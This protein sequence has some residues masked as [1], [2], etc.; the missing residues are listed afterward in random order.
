[1][2]FS[3]D[4]SSVVLSQTS[5]KCCHL[6]ISI[7]ISPGVAIK[8]LHELHIIRRKVTAKGIAKY[9]IQFLQV[10]HRRNF[11]SQNIVHRRTSFYIVH[12]STSQKLYI[13]E[14]TGYNTRQVSK[15]QTGSALVVVGATK[16]R[17]DILNKLM[18]I[19]DTHT[20]RAHR[21]YI[22]TY[23]HNKL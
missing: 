7:T 12:R 20:P 1:M 5:N 22:H 18:Y 10:I 9:I 15:Q 14:N 6:Y 19:K 11:T 17:K 23:I 16:K 8:I 13:V 21:A 3:V 2:S 4:V